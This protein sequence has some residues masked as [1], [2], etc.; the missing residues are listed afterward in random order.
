MSKTILKFTQSHGVYGAGDIA[1]FEP[2][3]AA[4]FIAMRAAKLYDPDEVAPVVNDPA[5]E[6]AE[7][8]DQIAELR[9]QLAGKNKELA[10]ATAKGEPPAQGGAVDLAAKK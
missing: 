1:G 6:L 10:E 2:E 3:T 7:A 8:Q 9:A 5:P 4:R